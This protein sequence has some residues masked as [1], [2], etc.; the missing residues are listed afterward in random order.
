MYFVNL[1]SL[2]AVPWLRQTPASH[3]C[4]PTALSV[5]ERFVVDK[6][7]TGTGFFF[8]IYFGFPISVSFHQCTMLILIY[9][10]LLPEGKGK[11]IPLQ[12]RCGPEGTTRSYQK[13]KR[14]KPGNR[15]KRRALR[16]SG[17]IE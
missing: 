12:A 6:I 8:T 13:D 10:L 1:K 5:P 15:P 2:K 7:G 16:K 11:V 3:R 9:T 14:E 4:G 17:S